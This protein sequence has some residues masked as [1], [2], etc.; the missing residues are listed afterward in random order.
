[1]SFQDKTLECFDCSN[2][3]TF[4]VEEQEQFQS[5]GYANDPKRCPECR[6]ARKAR[7]LRNSNNGYGNDNHG[8]APRRQMFPTVCSECGK[9]TEVPFEPREGRPVY[10]SDCYRKV[11][12]STSATVR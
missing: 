3:Y 1:M 7:Q 2:T 8:Y 10:C 9:A 6:Q 4:S 5:R 12:L 11:R